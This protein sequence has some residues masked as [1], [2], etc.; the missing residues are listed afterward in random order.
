MG[1]KLISIA[2][3]LFVIAPTVVCL[4]S[5]SEG[6]D[7]ACSMDTARSCCCESEV[8]MPSPVQIPDFVSP[9]VFELP[10]L[11]AAALPSMAG[12]SILSVSSWD[13]SVQSFVLRHPPKSLYLTYQTLLI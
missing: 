1:R 12:P 5:A 2:L 7:M 10:G 8:R 3:A 9:S 4:C 13:G 11:G 6:A